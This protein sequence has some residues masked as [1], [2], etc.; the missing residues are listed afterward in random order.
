MERSGSSERAFSGGQMQGGELED[1]DALVR[2][3]RPRI[4]RFILASLRSRE[5]AENLTQ[6]C[7]V[8][9]YQARTG[10][11]GAASAATWFLHLVQWFW[12]RGSVLVE[13]NDMLFWGVFGSL[14]MVNALYE[15][16]HPAARTLARD[17]TLREAA[18]LTLKTLATFAVV[19]TL[20]SFWTAESVSDWT[21]MMRTALALPAWS[22]A[23]FAAGERR[24]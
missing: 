8:R 2:L 11:R 17:R 7:L 4:F 6:D 23:R 21:L 13:S 24:S 22:A 19:C 1:F 20:W 16:R 14:V 5:T 18:V 3:H 10:F 15:A 9:A 12:I